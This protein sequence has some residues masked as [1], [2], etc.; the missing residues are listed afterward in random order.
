MNKKTRNIDEQLLM[1]LMFSIVLWI[2]VSFSGHNSYDNNLFSDKQFNNAVVDIN[3]N[4]INP[5][6]R[7]WQVIPQDLS[8]NEVSPGYSKINYKES[9]IHTKSLISINYK[10]LHYSYLHIK[11][12]ITFIS[13]IP[14]NSSFPIEPIQIS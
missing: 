3:S 8:T 5:A 12:T 1:T 13:I 7:D 4:G 10:S 2:F 11:P 6:E 14:I 9:E